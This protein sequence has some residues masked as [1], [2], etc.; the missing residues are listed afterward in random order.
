MAGSVFTLGVNEMLSQDVN[1]F[2]TYLVRESIS[3]TVIPLNIYVPL[4]FPYCE[5]RIL[6]KSNKS[7]GE[8]SFYKD[9]KTHDMI[10]NVLFIPGSLVRKTCL[11][12]RLRPAN[13]VTKE[14]QHGERELSPV[15]VM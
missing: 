5:L 15:I 6:D 10:H 1:I 9:K 7:N 12:A 4:K 14:F 13:A 11:L 8:V 2:S 3:Y